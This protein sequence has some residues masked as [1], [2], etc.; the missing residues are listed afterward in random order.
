MNGDL[1]SPH[2]TFS[3]ASLKTHR[4]QGNC[5]AFLTSHHCF[6]GLPVVT[7]VPAYVKGDKLENKELWHCGMATNNSIFVQSGVSQIRHSNSIGE[8]F[9]VVVRPTPQVQSPA[10]PIVPSYS[11]DLDSRPPTHDESKPDS[12]S[13]PPPKSET[14]SSE[15]KLPQMISVLENIAPQKICFSKIFSPCA[16]PL[17]CLNLLIYTATTP[18]PCLL[19]TLVSTSCTDCQSIIMQ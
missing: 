5:S 13:N 16:G 3:S 4:Q 18:V 8:A 7:S 9:D 12:H 15:S 14:S 1:F 2:T 19:L 11:I 6:A 10:E 17:T